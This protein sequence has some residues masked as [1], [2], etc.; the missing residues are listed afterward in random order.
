LLRRG[1]GGGIVVSFMCL[2]SSDIFLRA[3]GILL[4]LLSLSEEMCCLIK[5]LIEL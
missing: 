1:G 3:N 2:A 5:E 4:E